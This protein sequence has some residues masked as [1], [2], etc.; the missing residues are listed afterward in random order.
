MVV[1]EAIYLEYK[2]KQGEVL[3]YKTTV[4][5]E[6]TLQ[7]GSQHAT[8]TSLMEMVM[9]QK[10][11]EVTT[12]GTMGV[13]V[14]IEA[15]GLKRDGEAVAFEEGQDPTGKTVSMKMKKNG[16]VVQTSMDLPFSQPPF[17]SRA[18]KKG[19][20]WTGDSKIPVPITNENGEV[21]GHREVTLRYHYSLWDF[22]RVQGYDCAEI[23]VSCPE[24]TIPLHDKIEQRISATGTTYFAHREGRLVRSEVE[25][26]SQISASETS[27]KNHIKVRVELQGDTSDGAGSSSAASASSGPSFGLPSGGDE[28]IIR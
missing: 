20:T 26:E 14:T 21:T 2:M 9:V 8:G 1:G 23:R 7:E 5:S 13:D 10:A 6:Q 27:I 24:S 12:E 3:R 17:P 22:T 16:E 4:Q 18:I 15:V 28:F 25:T 11:T 19:E